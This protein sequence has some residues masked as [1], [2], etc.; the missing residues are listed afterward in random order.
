MRKFLMLILFVPF[1]STAQV[2]KTYVIGTTI[3]ESRY[4]LFTDAAYIGTFKS[5]EKIWITEIK[6][7]YFR[8]RDKNGTTVYTLQS[9]L[10]NPDSLKVA[11]AK[12]LNFMDSLQ[13]EIK[14]KTREE[15]VLQ[16][17][18]INEYV[19]KYGSNIDKYC[20]MRGEIMIGM[21]K[22][23]FGW[24]KKEKPVTINIT[25]TKYGSSEQYVFPE[26]KYYYFTNDKLTAIQD[27][28][29]Y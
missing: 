9:N 10:N 17:Q 29:N 8:S 22:L 27:Q 11:F 28:K 5:G 13:N 12:D 18:K 3:K 25:K 1:V 16:E 19:K 24:V 6:N 7:E 20:L 21:S 14:R 23:V 15:E 2:I 26:Y 4:K